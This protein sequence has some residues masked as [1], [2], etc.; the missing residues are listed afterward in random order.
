MNHFHRFSIIGFGRI[1]KQ[2]A[3]L[4]Q[5]HGVL[6]AICDIDE[7]KGRASRTLRIGQ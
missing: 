7:E 1:G 5:Q 4:I 6:T 3:E 2:H